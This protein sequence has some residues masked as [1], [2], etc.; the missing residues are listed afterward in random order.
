MCAEAVLLDT[1]PPPPLQY[2]DPPPDL[3]HLLTQEILYSHDIHLLLIIGMHTH[4]STRTNND[5]TVNCKTVKYIR[6]QEFISFSA[7]SVCYS[8]K[9]CVAVT[10]LHDYILVE[11]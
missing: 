3:L 2:P 6:S 1:D 7:F 8:V 10:K 4:R 9:N 5:K 11:C